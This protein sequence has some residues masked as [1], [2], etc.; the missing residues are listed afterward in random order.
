MVAILNRTIIYDGQKAVNLNDLPPEA[1]TYLSGGPGSDVQK[2]YKAVP[3]I[4]RGVDLIAN[5]VSTLPFSIVNQAG[6][7]ID[8][9]DDYQNKLGF[10]PNPTDLRFLI[11]ASMELLGRGYL[12][13]ERNLVKTLDLRYMVAT[14]ISPD[15]DE[16]K[17]LVGFKRQLAH[18]SIPLDVDDL[19]YFWGRDPF[20]EIGPPSNDKCPVQAAL[21]AAGVLYNLAEFAA[22]YFERG[23]IKPTILS[24]GGK[25]GMAAKQE[26]KRFEAWWQRAMSGIKNAFAS[27]VVSGEVTATVL[28]EGLGELSDSDLTKEQRE[29][30]LTA[31]GIPIT[32]I[33]SNEASGLGGGGVVTSDERKFYEQ[34]IVPA[35][36]AISS[37]LNE[38]L[39]IPMG[40]RWVDRHEALDVF[41]MDETQ[42]SQAFVHY[43]KDGG[44]RRSVVAKMIGLELPE[45]VTPED[46]DEQYEE[47]KEAAAE[48]MPDIPQGNPQ[49]PQQQ[50]M[51]ADLGRWEKKAL[52]KGADCEFVSE[53]I[54]DDVRASVL[55]GLAVATTDEEVKAAFRG[56]FPEAADRWGWN[57]P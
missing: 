19:V 46:L 34:K 11:A 56:P 30:V 12:F 48:R 7:E 36:Q 38:Q 9:S 26:R 2:Y 20:V 33:Y 23:A 15:I 29:D 49:N 14:S 10:L 17:G 42:R 31:L 32:V 57:Y 13:R 8:S 5:A 6:D 39:L 27:N 18:Q 4:W 37:K 45:G 53:H 24:L 50:A 51:R 25:G 43:V 1:W 40:Y 52:N 55:A 22:M 44:L 21:M 54:P 41:Q 47:D 28:G 16:E 3:L 35:A